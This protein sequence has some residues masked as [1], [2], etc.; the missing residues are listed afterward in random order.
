MTSEQKKGRDIPPKRNRNGG[1]VTLLFRKKRNLL[2]IREKYTNRPE[3]RW[4]LFPLRLAVEICI[5]SLFHFFPPPDIW[6]EK[7]LS[8][9]RKKKT[10][11]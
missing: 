11:R 2:F 3:M 1:G 4:Q 10:G 6:W 5:K 7:V 9:A 8:H